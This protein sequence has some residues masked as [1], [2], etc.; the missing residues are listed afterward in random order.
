[1]TAA[2]SSHRAGVPWRT[3]TGTPPSAGFGISVDTAHACTAAVFDLL[4]GLAPGTV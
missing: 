4:A 3:R 1:M 2:A